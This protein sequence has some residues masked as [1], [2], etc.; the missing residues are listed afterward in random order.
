MPTPPSQS[1]D[2]SIRRVTVMG[3]GRFGG[4][5]GVARWWL[6]RGVD[7]HV[8]DQAT[9]DQL[10]E[11]VAVLR[12]HDRHDQLTFQLGEHLETD[13]TETDLV[14]ANPAVA[15]P[16][17]N[18]YLQ[19]AW[20]A[21]VPV[22]TEIA[23]AITHLNRRRVIGI[24]GTAG[25][26]TTAAMTHHALLGCG[27]RSILA[28]NIGG[29][30]LLNLEE[31][32]QVDAVVLELSSAMLWWLGA[33]DDA[34]P[35]APNWSPSIA[36]TTNV[37]ANHLD[38]HGTESHYRACKK[39]ITRHQQPGDHDIAAGEHDELLPLAVPGMHNQHNAQ[40]AIEAVTRMGCA[41][42]DQAIE[43][44]STFPGLPHRLERLPSFGTN[45]CFNDSK[46]TTPGA[47]ML[48]IDAMPDPARVHLIAGGYDK[49]LE[50]DALT[51]RAPSLAGLYAIGATG[52]GLADASGG[53]DCGTLE[54]AVACAVSR[55]QDGDVLLLS[56]GCASWDQF[57]NYEERGN[58]FRSI[59]D[60]IRRTP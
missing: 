32:E 11:P 20:A 12:E 17:A 49:G 7:V 23:L 10:A 56:P 6:D 47:T 59:L 25:K 9:Q 50:M 24:T 22:T 21:G 18:P 19:A 28:G 15:L 40:L 51:Q 5:Q 26:S 14:V 35:G 36:I 42:R 33:T 27:A 2:E 45:A 48:A 13:F 39:G 37:E 3:L 54:A 58:R 29:S 30:L 43:A 16:W 53:H 1:I 60:A 34:P 8:T 41:S 31:L 52:A 55:M 46:S 4:G 38:W 44:V 57:D